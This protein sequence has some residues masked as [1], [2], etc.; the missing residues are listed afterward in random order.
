[1]DFRAIMKYVEAQF[2]LPHLMKY[3]RGVQSA[4][5]M[6][7]LQQKPLKPSPEPMVSCPNSKQGPPPVY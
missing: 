1:M 4:S 2:N 3:S 7:N 5:G 6:L